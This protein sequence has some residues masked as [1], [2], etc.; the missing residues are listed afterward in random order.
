MRDP[1]NG[2]YMR[3]WKRVPGGD[4]QK[5]HFVYEGEFYGCGRSGKSL[6]RM[7]IALA[8][9]GTLFAVVYLLSALVVSEGAMW[10][11]VGLFQILTLLGVIYLV[12]AVGRIC[13]SGERLTYRDYHAGPL[14]LKKAAL[15]CVIF[16]ALTLGAELLY[17]LLFSCDIGRELIF[18]A[19][20]LIYT[21][22]AGGL[23]RFCRKNPWQIVDEV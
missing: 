9:A 1:G 21:V 23:L 19:E 2:W 18:V 5:T 3:G 22:I 17:M 4:G 12:M 8:A 16:S 20:I 7:K 6:R 13:L 10:R 11:W 14:R 15:A